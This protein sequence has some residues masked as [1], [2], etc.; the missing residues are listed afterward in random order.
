MSLAA[1]AA[2]SLGAAFGNMEDPGAKAA[3]MVVSAIASIALGFAQAAAAKDTV[4]S[5]WAWLLWVS[6]GLAAMATSIATVH[7]LTG[8]AEGGMVKGNSYS[9]DNIYGM[10]DGGAGGFVG[11][12]LA[13]WCSAKPNRT[14]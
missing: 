1:N 11:L 5:G 2:N 3:G 14:R 4:A 9:G 10:V 8:Y 12:N 7:S 6:A 13:K